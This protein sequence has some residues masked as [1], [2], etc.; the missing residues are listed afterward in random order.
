MIRKQEYSTKDIDSILSNK[1]TN[2]DIPDY[3][4]QD[5]PIEAYENAVNDSNNCSIDDSTDGRRRLARPS[6]DFGFSL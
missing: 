1:R 6:E 2:N 5:I 3:A 4:K